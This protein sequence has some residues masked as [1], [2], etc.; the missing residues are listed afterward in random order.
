MFS[1]ILERLLVGEF[2]VFL[3][4]HERIVS[5]MVQE[6][7]GRSSVHDEVRLLVVP[8]TG[9]SAVLVDEVPSIGSEAEPDYLFGQVGSREILVDVFVKVSLVPVKPGVRSVTLRVFGFDLVTLRVHLGHFLSGQPFDVFEQPAR[10]GIRFEY[11]AP[12]PV[13]GIDGSRKPH[14]A[15][16]ILAG[17][18]RM[19]R[20]PSEFGVH[21]LVDP[22]DSAGVDFLVESSW[23]AHVV[24]VHA[25]SAEYD[26]RPF[27]Q[28]VVGVEEFHDH[29]DDSEK[30][31]GA[32][33]GSHLL[34][35]AVEV[36]IHDE[37][38]FR[39]DI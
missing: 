14:D 38:V 7:V 6:V 23:R 15:G 31:L 29:V 20:I 4:D 25:A 18:I 24:Q 34:V 19:V 11:A 26:E 35:F 27:F 17:E 2:E 5:G 22:V 32:E 33:F 16:D 13:L 12:L 37:I 10:P 36:E 21:E 3:R 1:E 39:N 8:I 30:F 28:K 9:V